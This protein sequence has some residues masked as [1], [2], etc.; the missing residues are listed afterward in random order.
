MIWNISS[1]S[2]IMFNW[3]SHG[4]SCYWCLREIYSNSIPYSS[5]QGSC[6]RRCNLSWH[7]QYFLMLSSPNTVANSPGFYTRVSPK[8]LLMGSV[9]AE[10]I[11]TKH[12]LI[13]LTLLIHGSCCWSP[14]P[15]VYIIISKIKNTTYSRGMEDIFPLSTQYFFY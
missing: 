1:F 6:C 7:W 2:S 11:E 13:S 12:L 9:L 14:H 5:Q 10:S 8:T 3:N 15:L 4:N